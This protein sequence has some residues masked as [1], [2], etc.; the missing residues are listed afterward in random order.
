METRKARYTAEA[1]QYYNG[2]VFVPD[3]L[4]IIEL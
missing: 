3:D 1:K 2:T 4:E